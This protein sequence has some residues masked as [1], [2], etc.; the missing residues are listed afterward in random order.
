MIPPGDI[1]D[2]AVHEL[3]RMSAALW[4][5]LTRKLEEQTGLANGYVRCGSVEFEHESAIGSLQQQW[6]HVGVRAELLDRRQLHDILP[7]IDER[8]QGGVFLPEFAQVRNPRHLPALVAACMQSGVKVI[9]HAEVMGWKIENGRVRSAV[10][11]SGE[12]EGGQFLIAGG[13]WSSALLAAANSSGDIEPIRGQ[14]V[15]LRAPEVLFRQVLEQGSRYLVPR[16]DGRILIGSTQERAGFAKETMPETTAE[17]V[18]FAASLVPALADV[19]IERSWSGLRPWAARGRPLIGP[20]PGMENLFVASG[21][22]RAGLSNSPATGMLVR[23]M[24]TGGKT[25][26]DLAPFSLDAAV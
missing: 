20:V 5:E 22:F 16:D 17:L 24:L 7:I 11:D 3:A 14:I 12:F 4:P 23:E 15:L 10:T 19:T 21:H 9:P 1:E 8:W 18:R 13:A 2:L 6:E 25:S 26:I